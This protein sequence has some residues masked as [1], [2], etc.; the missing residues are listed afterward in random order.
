VKDDSEAITFLRRVG[1][2][3]FTGYTKYA[4]WSKD[5]DL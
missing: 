4:N 5:D 3:R 2:Y 1:Y